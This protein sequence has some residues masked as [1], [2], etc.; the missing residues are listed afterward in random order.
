MTSFYDPIC[1]KAFI[2]FLTDIPSL[3]LDATDNID[4]AQERIQ[5]LL[6]KHKVDTVTLDIVFYN[7]QMGISFSLESVDYQ[8]EF[9]RDLGFIDDLEKMFFDQGQ[10]AEKTITDL[11]VGNWLNCR[12]KMGTEDGQ[13]RTRE[14][15]FDFVLKL[16]DYFN[17]LPREIE[18]MFV[19]EDEH[20]INLWRHLILI[21]PI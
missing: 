20:F 8:L 11:N 3:N 6:D 17:G 2:N 19:S 5:T 21:T 15:D 1:N 12:F 10:N 7:G 9:D 18:E 13:I 4:H 16:R 14:V